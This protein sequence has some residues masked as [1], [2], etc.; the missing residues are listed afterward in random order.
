MALVGAG[1]KTTAMLRLARELQARGKAVVV[2]TTT[3]IRPP[4]HRHRL[5]LVLGR[6][7]RELHDGVRA[8]LAD[9]D[10]PVAG[11]AVAA[12]GKVIG[13]VAAEVARLAHL[14]AVDHVLVEAD[15]ARGKPFK[16]PRRHE[17]VIPAAASLVIVV[18]GIDAVGYRLRTAAHHVAPVRAIARAAGEDV[19]GPRTIARVLL[20]PAGGRKGTPPRARIVYLINKADT[21]A[22]IEHAHVLSR[23]LLA[24][25]ARHVVIAAL[26][27]R[28]AIL[29]VDRREVR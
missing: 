22:R 16:A 25:G 26:R 2:T 11:H 18:V 4:G 28:E 27:R 19:L 6:T 5:R 3:R 29:R 8:A 10:V 14:R 23:E 15:G 9:G 20:D 24:G 13:V 21:A 7:A 12:D 1:G 17:P